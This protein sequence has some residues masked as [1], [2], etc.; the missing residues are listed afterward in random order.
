[1]GLLEE[2]KLTPEELDEILAESPSLRGMTFGYVSEYKLRKMWFSR[3]EFGKPIKYDN[4]DRSKKGDIWVTYKG[5][6]ISVE[7][8]CLQSHTVREEGG[9][10]SGKF[11]CDASD[12][13]TATLP[14]GKKIQTTCLV[15]GEF[16]LLAVCLFEFGREWRFA[17]ARNKCLPRSQWRQYKRKDREFLLATLMPI[18]WP[19]QPPYEADPFR[20]LDEIVADK[21]A[22]P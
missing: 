14:S 16:D 2:W 20:L 9:R 6:E 10:Y 4:H 12:R 5:V 8:K 18:T 19:L 11:Q 17:F 22:H 1:V 3:E 7:A 21:Q 15:V 13:R